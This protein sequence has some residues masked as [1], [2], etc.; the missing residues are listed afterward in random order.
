MFNSLIVFTGRKCPF[1]GCG[2]AF[3]GDLVPKMLCKMQL[4]KN[5]CG[6]T[7]FISYYFIAIPEKRGWK[8][9][10]KKKK[11]SHA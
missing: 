6:L 10:P 4:R 9:M 3:L 7:G 11:K 8:E 1:L 5:C 2:R